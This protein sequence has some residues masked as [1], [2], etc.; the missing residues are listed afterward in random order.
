MGVELRKLREHAGIPAREAARVA[1]VD[2]GKM[3][4]IE[5]GRAA[6]S[7]ERLR[8]L[9]AHYGVTDSA[10]VDALVSLATERV[11][12]WWEKYHGVVTPRSVDL[13]VAEWQARSISSLQVVHIPGLLQT[14]AYA[15]SLF[16]Q[17]PPELQPDDVE[18]IVDFRMRRQEL[19]DRDDP[20]PYTVFVHE[21]ALRMRVGAR[22]VVREQLLQ[23]AES[24]ERPGVTVRV[25]PFAA[26]GY[27]CMGYTM[28][29]LASDVPQLDTVQVDEA[30]GSVFLDAEEWLKRY[31]TV[32][33]TLERFALD[34]ESSRD[35]VLSIA[36][37]V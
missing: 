3:S 37:E 31:R 35:L 19:L 33:G 18:L 11:R 29:Y 2:Q 12:G 25:V 22:S 10:L 15:R 34:A 1:G 21:A 6:V 26:E 30:L 5:S 7:E 32:L 4:N 20:P 14:E 13:A 36:R 9:A 28:Q 27:V 23:V 16:T 8:R 24:S 17:L